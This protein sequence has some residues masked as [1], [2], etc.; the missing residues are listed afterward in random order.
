[1][2]KVVIAAALLL[3][4]SADAAGAA[5]Q[6]CASRGGPGWR[7][8][9]GQCVGWD[10]LPGQC[11]FPPEKRCSFEGL[12]YAHAVPPGS[13]REIWHR[14]R[15]L[16]HLVRSKLKGAPSAQPAAPAPIK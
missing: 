11:G 16:Y 1:M 14:L 2:R 3:I 9:K 7:N 15:D 12:Q 4:V 10:A 8:E 5:T 13:S 6:G